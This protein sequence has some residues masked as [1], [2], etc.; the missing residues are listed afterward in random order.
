MIP[1]L[2]GILPCTTSVNVFFIS[3]RPEPLF[4][5]IHWSLW[6]WN[7]L[8]L[9]PIL[10]CTSPGPHS[11][12]L[13]WACVGA[14]KKV[15]LAP[16]NWLMSPSRLSRCVAPTLHE[17]F[18]QIFHRTIMT[19]HVYNHDLLRIIERLHFIVW[20]HLVI[21]IET[22]SEGFIFFRGDTNRFLKPSLF[23]NKGERNAC[24]RWCTS[25]DVCIGTKM[26]VIKHKIIHQPWCE[27]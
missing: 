16:G 23:C 5:F 27:K 15:G 6:I 19:R 9:M 20:K 2:G 14:K 3:S 7:S 13:F 1:R 4:T 17:E 26:I 21:A 22:L 8:R 12:V 25:D 10:F 11:S 24:L 18:M